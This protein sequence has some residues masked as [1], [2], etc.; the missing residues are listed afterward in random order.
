[1]V[2]MEQMSNA[3][4]RLGS[5]QSFDFTLKDTEINT[6]FIKQL[7]LPDSTSTGSTT[8]IKAVPSTT[9]KTEI[10]LTPSK[11]EITPSQLE[12]TSG[13]DSISDG[14]NSLKEELQKIWDRLNRT[15]SL[16]HNCKNCGAKLE[17]DEN[18]PIFHCKYCGSTYIIG[19][20][21]PNSVY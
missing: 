20:V 15:V 12:L 2:T 11:L 1:M 10:L 5:A 16:V 7:I 17:I 4:G 6:P 8:Y 13:W 21:Q 19:A 18:K 3:V 9:N 14:N